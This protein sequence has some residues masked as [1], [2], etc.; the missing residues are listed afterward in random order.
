MF[1]F[2]SVAFAEEYSEPEIEYSKSYEEWLKL[3]K[4]EREKTTM[5]PMFDVPYYTRDVES[6]DYFENQYNSILKAIAENTEEYRLD[7]DGVEVKVKDQGYTNECWAFS[8]TSVLE[9]TCY[10]VCKELAGLEF[11]PRHIDYSTVSEFLDKTLEIE[12]WGREIR[13]GG[14]FDTGLSYIVSGKGPILEEDMPAVVDRQEELIDSSEI[15]GKEVQAKVKEAVYF[16]TVYKEKNG[17]EIIYRDSNTS[18][19]N[20]LTEDEALETRVEMKEHI[21]TYGAIYTQISGS[22]YPYLNQDTGAFNSDASVSGHAVTIIGWDDNYPKE[23]FNK[24]YMPNEDGAWI[25]LNSYGTSDNCVVDGMEDYVRDGFYYVSYEDSLVEAGVRGIR[26]ITKVDHDYLYQYDITASN[27]T[28]EYNDGDMLKLNFDS[29]TDIDK[30][31][32]EVEK[33]TE[34]G[35]FAGQEM[36][37]TIYYGDN[38]GFSCNKNELTEVIPKT[39]IYPGYNTLELKDLKDI[40]SDVFSIII[41]LNSAD[42]SN[43]VTI[44]L[45]VVTP[46]KNPSIS[47]K[48]SYYRYSSSNYYTFNDTKDRDYCVKVFTRSEPRELIEPEDVSLNKTELELDEG[49]I[50]ILE[51]TIIPDNTNTKNKLTW[52]SSNSEVATVTQDGKVEAKKE[53]TAQISVITENNKKAICEVTVNKKIIEAESIFL[54]Q[55]EITIEE[56]KNYKLEATIEPNNAT[57][58]NVSWSSENSE[59]AEVDLNR[60]CYWYKSWKH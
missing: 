1:L 15:E 39:K 30:D 53:G 33:I 8:L 47:K 37:V 42:S 24:D 52:E 22:L 3:S 34:I 41:K 5:P 18:P 48:C 23:N 54:N 10:K 40:E 21:M 32:E 14:N 2:S 12:T 36:Y 58:K 20:I 44:P 6:N 17:N 51:A 29:K 7:E 25:V 19:S 28:A 16:P 26:E 4:E 11:S 60:K 31:S 35:L 45:E 56:E 46:T 27:A 43:K 9:T 55:T 49:D 13:D 57:D 50:E 38:I 59:I